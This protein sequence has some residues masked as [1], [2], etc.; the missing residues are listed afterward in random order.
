MS[1]YSEKQI[2]K[3]HREFSS[4]K[5]YIEKL[6]FFNTA[7]NIIP[8][9]F[10]DFDPQLKYLFE[11]EKTD[12]LI[13][14]FRNERNNP[15]LMRKNF[16]FKE[17]YVFNI[18]PAN[19]NSAVYSN[20]ILSLFLSRAPDFFALKN[21]TLIQGPSNDL[22]LEEANGLINKI[23]CRLRYAYDK[24]LEIQCMSVFYAGFFDR[25]SN[26]IHFP[27]KKRKFIELFLYAQGIIYADYIGALKKINPRTEN[28]ERELVLERLND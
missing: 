7:F 8:F 3:L 17:T 20:Y 4:L 23:E 6:S 1:S 15:G 18:K 22:L 25:F 12:A 9:P 5:R 19:S 26:N 13:D 16:I 11:K 21:G 14:I 2:R 24:S 27:F 10:P 28:L